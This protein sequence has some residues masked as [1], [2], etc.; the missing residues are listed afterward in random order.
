LTAGGVGVGTAAGC[1]CWAQ[2]LSRTSAAPI[3]KMDRIRLVN[4]A[5]PDS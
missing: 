4:V 5:A 2:A 1:P 3:P